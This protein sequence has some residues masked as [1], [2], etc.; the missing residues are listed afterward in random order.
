MCLIYIDLEKYDSARTLLRKSLLIHAQSLSLMHP[1]VGKIATALG[2]TYCKLNNLPKAKELLEGGLIILEKHYG[3]N[4][5]QTAET[6][7]SLGEVYLAQGEIKKAEEF[8][9]QSLK[10]LE[11]NS[12]V[13]NHPDRH[14][15]L[16]RVATLY[17]YQA[18][19]AK[20][21]HIR[22]I[23]FK[24]LARQALNQALKVAKATFPKDSEH[25]NRIQKRLISN[26]Y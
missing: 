21:N 10:I 6:L 9:R 17:E 16:E 3:K 2:Y 7:R 23:R 25:I 24:Q 19:L 5:F 20:N 12:E 11:M 1:T 4:H 18:N 14:L 8:I 15:I 26:Y 13:P 22:A